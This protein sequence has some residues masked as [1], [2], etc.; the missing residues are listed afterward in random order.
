MRS[1]LP[2][3]TTSLAISASNINRIASGTAL[4][5]N[6]KGLSTTARS[7]SINWRW[8][9]AK[10]YTSAYSCIIMMVLILTYKAWLFRGLGSMPEKIGLAGVF[11]GCSLLFLLARWLKKRSNV[12]AT[13]PAAAT[14][15]PDTTLSFPRLATRQG[16]RAAC[17]AGL[18]LCLLVLP[19]MLALVPRGAAPL[20]AV[21]GLC[22]IGTIAANPRAT[23]AGCGCRRLCW[24]CCCCG[25]GCR[26]C[27]RSNRR[28]V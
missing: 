6:F 14:S 15:A 23:G 26:R 5:A 10:A 2:R 18:G 20:V 22:A 12:L 24:G 17:E 11:L 9:I 8:V 27:G 13:D 16:W 7:I 3:K 28:A 4:V 25:A 19:T 21:A 1:S